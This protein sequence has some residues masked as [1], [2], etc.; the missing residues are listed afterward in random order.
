MWA[1]VDEKRRKKVGSFKHLFYF[2]YQLFHM[3]VSFE[4][5]TMEL[6]KK[7]YFFRWSNCKK[8]AL[9]GRAHYQNQFSIWRELGHWNENIRKRT[10]VKEKKILTRR[11]QE[12][13]QDRKLTIPFYYSRN[14]SLISYLFRCDHA[15]LKRVRPSVRPSIHPKLFS[16]E[17]TND[18]ETGKY[19]Q[20]SNGQLATKKIDWQVR[21]RRE[22]GGKT[23]TDTKRS[24]F[25]RDRTLLK[26]FIL[27]RELR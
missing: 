14:S 7:S 21:W 12:W 4:K 13:R 11:H 18:K 27:R 15:S 3:T 23:G 19:R 2:W 24:L 9:I 8:R 17:M 6:K 5:F 20:K 10:M 1:N 22:T 16:K 25:R 26:E